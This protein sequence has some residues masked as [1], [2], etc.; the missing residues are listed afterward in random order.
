[1]WEP[2]F[3]ETHQVSKIGEATRGA[4]E[5]H[6]R[7]TKEF[8]ECSGIRDCW[9]T[10]DARF[11][12][13]QWISKMIMA[14]PASYWLDEDG[15]GRPLMSY[16]NAAEMEGGRCLYEAHENAVAQAVEQ[17]VVYDIAER[18]V[19]YVFQEQACGHRLT[20]DVA[21]A[22][23]KRLVAQGS[24][25][26]GVVAGF[27]YVL[28]K[29]DGEVKLTWSLRGLNGFDVQQ[30]AKENGGNGHEA[31]AGFATKIDGQFRVTPYVEICN[32]LET[33]LTGT[34]DAD[35]R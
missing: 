27:S 11:L 10:S 33:H 30:F 24:D 7:L 8:A 28:D 14:K 6:R 34:T 9:V 22:T 19:L 31:A 3:E 18:V 23:R 17:L 1:V 20:S 5:Y 21:E 25:H 13:G 16:L 15:K 2:I 35:A 29:P 4:G 32:R 12:R 26:L